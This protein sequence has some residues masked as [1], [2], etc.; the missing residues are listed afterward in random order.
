MRETSCTQESV[1]VTTEKGGGR[2][3]RDR[4]TTN[5][6]CYVRLDITD[7]VCHLGSV[8]IIISVHLFERKIHPTFNIMVSLPVLICP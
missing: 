8:F 5:R 6:L 1:T 2:G 3:E 4:Q 7:Y